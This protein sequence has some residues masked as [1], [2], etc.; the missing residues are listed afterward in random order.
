MHQ[1]VTV[2]VLPHD[3]QQDVISRHHDAPTAGHL[4][5]EKTLN[6]L[7]SGQM[8]I[9]DSV[10]FANSLSSLCHNQHHYK[11]FLLD[12]HGKW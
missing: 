2:P 11:T 1:S 10:L 6:R 8:S 9:V 7:P 5:V 3:L 4:G 12:S